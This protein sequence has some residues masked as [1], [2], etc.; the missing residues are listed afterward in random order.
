M[1]SREQDIYLSVST[2]WDRQNPNCRFS[3]GKRRWEANQRLIYTAPIKAL[4]N[5]KYQ[6]FQ[7]RYGR[8][9]GIVTGDV[10]HQQTAPIVV[11]TT[12]ILRNMLIRDDSRGTDA[13]WIV[14]DEIHYLNHPERGTVWEGSHTIYPRGYSDPGAFGYY[15]QRRAA[16]PMDGIHWPRDNCC[17]ACREG[18]SSPAHVFHKAWP[19]SREKRPPAGG[20]RIASD[21]CRHQSRHLGLA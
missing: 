8:R 19:S 21:R 18:S 3:C 7:R 9:I 11:M 4:V 13:D 2:Y 10:S 6:E 5:Q 1:V 16:G 14:F 20:G 17:R 15:S 12:E